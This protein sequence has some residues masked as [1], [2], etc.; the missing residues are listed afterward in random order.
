MIQLKARR[1]NKR[2]KML[3]HIKKY[4]TMHTL[5]GAFSALVFT[6]SKE[7]LL[8]VLIKHS[9]H[10]LDKLNAAAKGDSSWPLEATT[11]NTAELMMHFAT[12]LGR[13][14]SQHTEKILLFLQHPF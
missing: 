11:L 5:Q 10:K 8:M 3:N 6:L 4:L 9:K 14:E 13:K 7:L 2:Q 12:L 1:F